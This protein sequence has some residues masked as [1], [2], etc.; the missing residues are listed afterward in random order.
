MC[1]WRS[2]SVNSKMQSQQGRVKENDTNS[3]CMNEMKEVHPVLPNQ[4]DTMH[5]RP[6]GKIRLYTRTITFL[7]DDFACPACFL[8]HTA[9]H[10][11]RDPDPVAA[12]FNE[13]D[14]AT[15]VAHPSP[16]QK[17]PEAFLCLVGLS[18]HYTLDEETYPWFLYK[19]GEGGCVLLYMCYV[20]YGLFFFSNCEP[21]SLETTIGRIVPLLSVAPDHAE[22]ELDASVEIL[23]DEGGSG[24]QTVSAGGGKDVDIY[25]VIEVANTVVEDGYRTPSETSVS[26]KSRSTLKR[27]LVG[28]VLNAKVRV[29]AMP[30][31]PF[32]TASISS[33]PEREVRDYTN[34]ATGPN[35][36]VIGAPPRSF[37]PIMTTVTTITSTID[38][39]LVAKKKLVKPSLFWLILLRL[40]ELIPPHGSFRIYCHVTNGSRL[41]DGRFCREMVD[42]FAPPKFFTY[43]RGMEND[44]L[45]TEFNV[46]A[47]RQMSLSVEVRMRAE[48]NVKEKKMLNSVAKRQVELL[49]VKEGEIKNLKAQ[50]LLREAEAGRNAILKKERNALDVKVTELKALAVSKERELTDLNALVTY[51]KSQNDILVDQVHEVEISSS[52]LQEKVKVYES[53]MDQLDKFQ[54]DQMKVVNDKFDKLYIDFVEMALH[55]EEKFYPHLFTTVFGRRWLLTHGME[56]AIVKCLNSPKYIFALGAAISK[57]IEKG[58]Q[59]GLSV[60]IVHGKEGRALT[61]VPAHNPSAEVDYT[62]ALQQLQNVNFSLLMELKSNKDASMKGT[63]DTTPATANTNT[64]LSTTFASASSIDP[65]FVDDYEVV[66]AEDQA[67]ADENVAS[68][69]N[70]DDAELNI[71]E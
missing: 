13:Q 9:K 42:K 47:A 22:S 28:A 43:V 64:A 62:S 8:W 7:V 37:V 19:N 36:R 32:M 23:F 70:V 38:P 69:P 68:F 10:I 14:Y 52:G 39:A 21:L 41:D 71:L 58:M 15:L 56:L 40:V 55:L 46:G 31:L 16:F 34:S 27:L 44:Q 1:E 54:D 29:A 49:K 20:L 57:A 67:V 48:Y 5:G 63:S 59:D 65:I 45:F 53:C 35:L 25:P 4:G 12:D 30:T 24:N 60:G 61:D 18:R 33:T 17:F 3:L 66:G 51:V 2:D 11:I 26:G 50:M 6:A